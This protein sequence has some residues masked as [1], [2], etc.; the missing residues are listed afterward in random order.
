MGQEIEPSTLYDYNVTFHIPRLSKL[1][2]NIFTIL[3]MF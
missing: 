3:K 2:V 1:I